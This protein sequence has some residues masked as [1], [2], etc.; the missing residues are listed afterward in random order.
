[1]PKFTDGNGDKKFIYGRGRKSDLDLS[2]YDDPASKRQDLYVDKILS[3]YKEDASKDEE[4]R[5]AEE[6]RR[7]TLV[8]LER[9]K[10]KAA[11]AAKKIAKKAQEARRKRMVDRAKKDMKKVHEAG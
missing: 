6:S 2:L 5:K 11:M 9:K 8:E 7:A 3:K 10:M 1:M 4:K